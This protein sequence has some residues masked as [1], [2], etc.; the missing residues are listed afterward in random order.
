MTV[1]DDCW[2]VAIPV[3]YFCGREK[4]EIMLPTGLTPKHAKQI[5]E[6]HGKV[7][8]YEPCEECKKMMEQ[9]VMLIQCGDNN[10]DYRTGKYVVVKDQAIPEIF[11][12]EYAEQA[13]KMRAMFVSETAWRNIG[14]PEGNQ[15]EN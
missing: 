8:N 5:K 14:L 15:D 13:L 7:V 3:C 10:Q 1:K 9:G 2:A 4:N 12:P 11:P 6:A